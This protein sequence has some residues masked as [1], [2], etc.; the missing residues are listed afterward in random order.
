MAATRS[1]VSVD[2]M[3]ENNFAEKSTKCRIFVF[4]GL[5]LPFHIKYSNIYVRRDMCVMQVHV[6][7]YL[8]D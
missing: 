5:H 8:A 2:Q 4:H 6:H 3:S 1:F 7:V